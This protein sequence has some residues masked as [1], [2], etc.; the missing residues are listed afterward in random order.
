[1]DPGGDTVVPVAAVLL[2]DTPRFLRS[3]HAYAYGRV[4]T[5]HGQ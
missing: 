3:D 1:M 5:H 2:F 4:L